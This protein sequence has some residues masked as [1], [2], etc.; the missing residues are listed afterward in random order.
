[1][2]ADCFV[3]FFWQFF[4]TL[5]LV[6]GNIFDI[7]CPNPRKEFAG[8]YVSPLC[9]KKFDVVMTGYWVVCFNNCQ[10]ENCMDVLTI[11][12]P[13]KAEL[14]LIANVA[15]M[16]CHADAASEK[17][18]TRYGGASVE[19][20]IVLV[21]LNGATRPYHGKR[22]DVAEISIHVRKVV[23]NEDARINAI[24]KCPITYEY[25]DSGVKQW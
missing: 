10:G 20:P 5:F 16:D 22:L 14:G 17:I 12:V 4:L 13:L 24:P 18:C 8:T 23:A 9:A 7:G 6:N 11:L 25:P 15:A 1:M 19:Y 3:V 21:F 2:M